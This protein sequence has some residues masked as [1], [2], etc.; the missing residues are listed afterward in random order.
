MNTF[1]KL[2][3]F[4]FLIINFNSAYSQED[5]GSQNLSRYIEEI[6]VTARAQEDQSVRDIPVAITA[7]SEDA[8]DALGI[9]SL[10]DIA[11]TSASLE[12]NRINSGSGVQIAVRGIASSPGSLGIEQ[13][14]AVMID[15][16]YFPQGRV[17]N[18]G[19]FDTGQVAILKGP[20]ALYFGKN[21][22][23]G[24]IVITTNDPGDEFEFKA[25]ISNEF[26]YET[27]TGEFVVSGP[28][29]DN[30]GARLALYTSEMDKGWI[31]NNAQATTYTTVDAANNFAPTVHTSPAPSGGYAPMAEISSARL[32]LMGDI[33]DNVSLKI[34]ASTTENEYSTLN[35]TEKYECSALDGIPHLNGAD[36]DNPGFLK[37]I[38]NPAGGLCN[39][40]RVKGINTIPDGPAAALPITG[41]FGGE[42][43]EKYESQIITADLNIELESVLLLCSFN[44]YMLL[45]SLFIIII[46]CNPIYI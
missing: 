14:V 2:V 29:S 8:M 1:T 25:K 31:K 5:T 21:A 7:F 15:G 37:A 27:K 36:P 40:D 12:I 39:K 41:Q 24:A 34:K 22:T 33:S 11:N 19:L 30:W 28:I 44:L 43:G 13:T 45:S 10:D 4:V 35:T 46:N 20:Q 6:V 18:E 9:E 42:L 32:T 17:I 16:V 38:A 26:E 3:L 23:A